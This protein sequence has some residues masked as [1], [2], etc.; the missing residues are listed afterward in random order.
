MQQV[1][2]PAARPREALAQPHPG[3]LPPP[4]RAPLSDPPGA[5]LGAAHARGAGQRGAERRGHDGR[6]ALKKEI[7]LLSACAII[8]GKGRR[9][10]RRRRAPC[11]RSRRVRAGSP[12]AGGSRAGAER[13]GTGWCHLS[14][15]NALPSHRRRRSG[16]KYRRCR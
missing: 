8:I 4:P 6:R 9:G 7:G 14:R 10:R 11:R 1:C 12:R 3:A 2:T 15:R 5:P 13:T 16:V